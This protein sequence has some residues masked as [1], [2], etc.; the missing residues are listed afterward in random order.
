MRTSELSGRV[1]KSRIEDEWLGMYTSHFEHVV[2]IVQDGNVIVARKITG[3]MFIP[4]G[5]LTWVV[6]ISTLEGFG[7]V[8]ESEFRNPH[9]IPGK[10]EI[11][12]RDHIRFHW[13]GIGSAEFRRDG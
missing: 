2:K 7:I 6:D 12:D 3:D 1:I 11:I 10:L 5:E 4:A 13:I 8:A 9:P